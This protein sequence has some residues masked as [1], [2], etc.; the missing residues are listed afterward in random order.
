L[1]SNI[2]FKQNGTTR[3]TTSKGYDNLNRLTGITNANAS[4]VVLDSHGYG[5]NSANQRT[6]MTNSDGSYWRYG[7]DSLG[8][9]TSAVKYWS[10]GKAAAGEQFGNNFDNIGNRINS[11]MGGNE[12]GVG[13]RNANYTANSLNQYTSRTVPGATDIIGSATNTSTVT[14]NGILAYRHGSYY[15]TELPISNIG[16]SVWQSVTNI[17]VLGGATNTNAM[18]TGNVFLPQNPESYVY[19][20]DGNLI[21]DGRF[22][23]SWDGENRLT[24]MT[25][26]GGAPTGSKYKLDLTYDYLGR[27][28]QKIVSTN[29]G[30]SY[31]AAFTNKFIYDKWNIVAVLDG[32]N[33]M[34]YSFTWGSDLFG[35]IQGAGGIGG[36]IAMTVY[37]GVNTGIY[38]YSYD[39]NGNV[40]TLI[41]ATNDSIVASY[42]YGPF[43]ELLRAVGPMAFVNPFRFSTKYQDDEAGLTYYGLRYYNSSTGRWLS[44]D[45]IAERGG[46]NIYAV[47]ENDLVDNLDYLGKQGLLF[48]P[49]PSDGQSQV[50]A[51]TGASNLPLPGAPDGTPYVIPDDPMFYEFWGY[52]KAG[53]NIAGK[54]ENDPSSVDESHL[55]DLKSGPAWFYGLP[56]DP[57]GAPC[58]VAFKC[59]LK[60]KCP[61]GALQPKTW[62]GPDFYILEPV[63]NFL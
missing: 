62:G 42:E 60:C 47:F 26:S 39:G 13:L 41:N 32:G 3:M 27:R 29:S 28:V 54:T 18:V 58:R 40:T 55:G 19:D 51:P 24:N 31:V 57:A 56:N 11:Q 53:V 35:S 21:S 16:G 48:G 25:S 61:Y 43:G 23:N 15:R 20:L 10:D 7:Y 34:L 49:P 38:F 6:S 22:T 63:H 1:V 4:S 44:R 2:T 59:G 46:R 36:L 33:H 5:L 37:S 12:N 45:P 52:H 30:S 9:V 8:Q 14:V 50:N 17:G